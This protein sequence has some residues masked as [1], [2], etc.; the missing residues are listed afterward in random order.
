MLVLN[1]RRAN[2]G[3]GTEDK[4][5]QKSLLLAFPCGR[6]RLRAR[7]AWPLDMASDRPRIAFAVCRDSLDQ[8]IVVGPE[9]EKEGYR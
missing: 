7:H 3:L 9:K 5:M 6:D 1:H 2:A 4:K 8:A